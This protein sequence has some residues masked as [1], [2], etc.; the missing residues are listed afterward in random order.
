MFSFYPWG[1]NVVICCECFEFENIKVEGEFT[2]FDMHYLFSSGGPEAK[3]KDIN[4]SSILKYAFHT[5][6]HYHLFR[7]YVA[8]RK[9][10]KILIWMNES[11]IFRYI[12]FDG[13]G[14]L[15]DIFH[16]SGNYITTTTFQALVLMW[17]QHGITKNSLLFASKPLSTSRTIIINETENS[18]FHFPDANYKDGLCALLVRTHLDYHVNITVISLKSKILNDYGCFYAGIAIGERFNSEYKQIK[19]T[20]E[21]NNYSIGQN[22]YS[23]NSS[24]ILVIYWYKG[25]SKINTSV[26]ISQTKCK[27]VL[28]E[29]CLMHYLCFIHK[30]SYKCHSYLHNVTRFSGVSLT[31]HAGIST[32]VLN[33]EDCTVLQFSKMHLKQNIEDPYVGYSSCYIGLILKHSVDIA[34]RVSHNQTDFSFS[35]IKLDFCDDMKSCLKHVSEPWIQRVVKTSTE[36]LRSSQEMK[37]EVLVELIRKR[38]TMGVSWIELAISSSNQSSVKSSLTRFAGDFLL[39][40][41]YF[42]LGTKLTLSHTAFTIFLLKSNTIVLNPNISTSLTVDIFAVSFY[43]EEEIC[44]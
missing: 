5:H 22:I 10:D 23:Y 21:S 17:S 44:E 42:H 32:F 43:N 38:L 7:F 37:G 12:V 9:L 25:Y 8:V 1:R 20:C 6:T 4:I 15:S 33:S 3:I 18:L 35:E 36:V 30:V 19:T 2:I 26:I 29:L 39:N 31:F 24:L 27:S 41:S 13:P 34:V 16:K 40:K 14:L 11:R 28:L